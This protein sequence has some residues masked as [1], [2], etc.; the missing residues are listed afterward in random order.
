MRSE[1][2][3]NF[4]PLGCLVDWYYILCC[5]LIPRYSVSF[6]WNT[7]VNM[8]WQY[9]GQF[10]AKLKVSVSP[11][12]KLLQVSHCTA[13]KWVHVEC[14]LVH[15]ALESRESSTM[16]RTRPRWQCRSDPSYQCI[17]LCH[18]VKSWW[19]VAMM[20]TDYDLVVIMVSAFIPLSPI[21]TTITKLALPSCL[22]SAI[23]SVSSSLGPLQG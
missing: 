17:I 20:T 2:V 15:I 12:M 21:P 5:V 11:G 7:P 9:P 1:R 22:V 8:K 6:Q 23:V 16:M 10:S 4:L 3:F 18:S 13:V 14:Q 19:W